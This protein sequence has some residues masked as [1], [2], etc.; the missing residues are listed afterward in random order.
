MGLGVSKWRVRID[1]DLIRLCNWALVSCDSMRH[2]NCQIG[3]ARD[4]EPK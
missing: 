4:V 3:F 2:Q 1:G